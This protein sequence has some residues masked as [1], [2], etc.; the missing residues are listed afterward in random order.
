M[1]ILELIRNA[2][3]TPEILS[4][5]SAYMESLSQIP[6]LPD[7][8]VQPLLDEGDIRERASALFALVNL[9]SQHLRGRECNAAKRA[10]RVFVAALERARSYGESS[11]KRSLHTVK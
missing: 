9:T 3:S 6:S 1:E 8:C 7:W 4:A 10:L 5:L 11:A 2:S